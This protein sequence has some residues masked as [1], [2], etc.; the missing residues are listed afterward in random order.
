MHNIIIIYFV[1]CL[2]IHIYNSS[3]LQELSETLQPAIVSAGR[4]WCKRHETVSLLV[5]SRAVQ[6]IAGDSCI[7]AVAVSVLARSPIQR[8][9]TR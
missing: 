6:S 1:V 8:Q 2:C 3:G 4:T 7:R 5:S 9:S